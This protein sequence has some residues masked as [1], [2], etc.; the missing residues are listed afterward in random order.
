MIDKK[1]II[2]LTGL[3]TVIFVVI[4]AK[5]F[6]IQVINSKDLIEIADNQ[7]FRVSKVYPYRKNIYDRNG[8]PLAINVKTYSIFT[9]PKK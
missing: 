1:R 6:Y 9:I 7:V 4:I 5:A 2:F 3:F 8:S